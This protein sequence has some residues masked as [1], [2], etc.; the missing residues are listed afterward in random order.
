MKILLTVVFYSFSF[1]VYSQN[2][3][4]PFRSKNLWGFADQKGKIKVS[5]KYDSVSID[6]ENFRWLVYK[7]NKTG[8]IDSS[9]NEK[10][11]VE[12]DSIERKT[13][14]SQDNDFYIFKNKKIG[15]ADIDGKIIFPCEYK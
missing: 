14:H 2:F 13:L 4:V 12:Y 6:N 7:N 11:P 10:L 1:L 9:G 8:V 5:P 3:R 15:Y